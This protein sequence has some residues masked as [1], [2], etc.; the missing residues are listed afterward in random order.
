MQADIFPQLIRIKENVMKSYLLGLFAIVIVIVASGY[1]TSKLANSIEP[2]YGPTNPSPK[3]KANAEVKRFGSVI[4]L[5]PEKE[6]LYRELHAEVWPEV[7]ASLKKANFQNFNIFLLELGGK[8]YLFSY[9]EY[10]GNDLYKDFARV[11]DNPI[12]CDKWDPMTDACEKRLP[13]TPKGEQWKSLE[14]LMHIP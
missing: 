10:T 9:V 13:G 11:A 3:Q 12:V 1:T 6:Q 7:V 5:L 4:E 8:K 2:I 14:T